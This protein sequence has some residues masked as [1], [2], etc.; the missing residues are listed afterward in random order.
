[1]TQNVNANLN[2]QVQ[3]T[4]LQ[5]YTGIPVQ[6]QPLQNG[7]TNN[8]PAYTSQIYQYPQT[9][10]YTPTMAIPASGVNINIINPTGYTPAQYNNNFGVPSS[11]QTAGSIPASA[12]SQS[13]NFAPLASSPIN[14]NNDIN[15]ASASG[16]QKTKQIVELTDDYIKTLESY[17]RSNDEELRKSGIKELI[18]RFEED[19][20][21]YENPALTALLNI[22]LQDI[23]PENRLLAMSPVSAGKAHGD[24]NTV[25][26]LQTLQKSDKIF[27]Q[28][29]RMASDALLKTTH[30]KITVPDDNPKT[31]E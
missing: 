26:L 4:P 15:N 5:Y 16:K 12:L 13:S 21:R 17:L 2:N 18:K 8:Q 29:A 22:A 25:K 28:E 14:I 24:E 10:L 23:K 1:M 3:G 9:S 19:S 30:N 20:S 31:K 6:N 11:V 27:G 7:Q